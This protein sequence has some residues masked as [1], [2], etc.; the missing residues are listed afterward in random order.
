MIKIVILINAQMWK[1]KM[2]VMLNKLIPLL[3][4]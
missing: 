3:Q 4:R 1:E 2:S